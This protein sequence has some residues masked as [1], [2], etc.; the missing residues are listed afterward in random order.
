A[1]PAALGSG[2]RGLV[3]AL[4]ASGSA[5]TDGP[6][7]FRPDRRGTDPR[8]GR[9][10]V[11]E[12]ARPGVQRRPRLDAGRAGRLRVGADA[13]RPARRLR[14][15]RRGR[16]PGRARGARRA[17]GRSRL[18]EQ[19]G[20]SDERHAPARARGRPALGGD[21]SRSG[22]EGAAARTRPFRDRGRATALRGHARCGLEGDAR[23]AP[24]SAPLRQRRGAAPSVD[25]H[26][27]RGAMSRLRFPA[28]LL[29]AYLL[30]AWAPL[31]LV[32]RLAGAP[33]GLAWLPGCALLRLTT[34]PPGGARVAA[35]WAAGMGVV[36]NGALVLLA[37]A[38]HVDFP[39]L[40]W[41]SPLL[42]SL[43]WLWIAL[44]PAP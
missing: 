37:S 16:G 12:R 35:G 4:G 21:R 6:D 22:C 29:G 24:L 1:L 19:L 28:A 32:L 9:L 31:P 36:W 33:C 30:A 17:L 5:W 39:A 44:L 11:R 26:A 41:I 23:T 13:H 20:L 40:V 3:R 18:R 34:L 15:S 7:R 27:V 38:L 10:G 2:G 43:L 14:R 42:G 8:V 25:G